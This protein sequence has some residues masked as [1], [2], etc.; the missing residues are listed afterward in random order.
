MSKTIEEV[1]KA[2]IELE[3]KILALLIAFENDNGTKLGYMNT[4]RERPKNTRDGYHPSQCM[5]EEAYDDMPFA[6]VDIS[7]RI[8]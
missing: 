1:K 3:G 4:E 2:K 6:N 5:P 7:L 8:E